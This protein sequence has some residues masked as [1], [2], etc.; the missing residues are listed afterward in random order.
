MPLRWIETKNRVALENDIIS[1]F[2]KE[3][4]KLGDGKDIDYRMRQLAWN[5]SF[6]Y[7][8]KEKGREE[9]YLP[10][11]AKIKSTLESKGVTYR[12]EA[13]KIRDYDDKGKIILPSKA[14]RNVLMGIRFKTRKEF[15]EEN[16]EALKESDPL[17]EKIVD[18]KL[19]EE[20]EHQLNNPVK[21][22]QFDFKGANINWLAGDVANKCKVP[23]ERVNK[24]IGEM[25]KDGDIQRVYNHPEYLQK[26]TI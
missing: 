17:E 5:Q 12:S 26:C 24:K 8:G 21:V 10:S 15:D 14:H 1:Q 4:C 19:V 25:L 7:F 11:D 22:D 3:R 23:L 6:K 16:E 2:I 9:R 18:D 20:I 13:T